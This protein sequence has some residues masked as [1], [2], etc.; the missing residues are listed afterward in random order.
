MLRVAS[1]GGDA[2]VRADQ[3]R[4]P[5]CAAIRTP[6]NGAHALAGATT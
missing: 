6:V 3:R 5:G 2:M 4:G 1:I